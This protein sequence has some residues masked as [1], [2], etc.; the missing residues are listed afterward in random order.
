MND[1]NDQ[2]Q[3]LKQAQAGDNQAMEAI[4]NSYMGL[5]RKI[6]HS[7][8]IT[9]GDKEDLLQMGMLALFGAVQSYQ[10]DRGAFASF[11]K[12]CIINKLL[13]TVRNSKGDKNKPLYNYV[14]LS[15]LE[16]Q[17]DSNNPLDLLI[18]KE[19]MDNLNE[20]MQTLLTRQEKQVLDMFLDG[21]SYDDICRQLNKSYKSVDGALQRA[22]KKL[23]QIKE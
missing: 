23:S 2:M 12:A 17:T 15:Q 3:L 21:Y 6:V 1:T 20:K 18:E 4:V 8:Y 10:E 9:G 22:R 7:F 13:A 11:A 14:E 19:L 16:L 5:V